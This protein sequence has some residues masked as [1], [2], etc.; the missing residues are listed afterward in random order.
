MS[1]IPDKSGQESPKNTTEDE[2]SFGVD[3]EGYLID[4]H[5]KVMMTF[6]ATT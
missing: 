2:V 4:A 3:E 1:S 6:K 5:G